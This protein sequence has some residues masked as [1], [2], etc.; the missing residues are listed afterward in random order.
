LARQF[1]TLLEG[2]VKDPD[3]R[4]S[5]L[6]LLT[7]AERHRLVI[8]FNA[9][10]RPVPEATLP[11]LFEAQVAR[12]PEAV[13]VICDGRELSAGEL[14]AGANRLAHHLCGL[15]GGPEALVGVCRERSFDMVVSLLAILKAGAAYLPLDLAYPEPRLAQMLADATPALVLSA[16]ALR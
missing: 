10:A 4:V 7:E 13:A 14:N 8:G 1:Q 15:G 3:C 16:G 2:A 9:T 12:A 11:T 5:E 6:L